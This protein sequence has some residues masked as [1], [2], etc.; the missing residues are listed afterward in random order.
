MPS[1]WEKIRVNGQEMDTYV[2]VPSGPEPFP[3]VVITHHAG[4]LD[5]F[6][7]DIA[8]KLAGEGYAAVA[9][10]FFHRYSEEMMADRSARSS[11]LDDLEIIADVSATVDFLRSHGSVDGERIGVTGFC[12]GGRIAWLTAATNP[13]IK[14]AA[15]YYPGNLMVVWG[16]GEEPPFE[17]ADRISC[18]MLV[19]FAELDTNPSQE[20]MRKLDAE[21]TRLGNAHQFYV[22]PG[23]DHAFMDYTGHRHHKESSEISWPRTL[24]FFGTH[25]KGA[26][27]V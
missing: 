23:A 1:F 19:H 16:S 6:T 21:L 7:R 13:H 9:P 3:A 12:M 18:P 27:A 17:M 15:P 25:L 22:Y 11:H 2:S 10:N 5:Q 14:A 26:V 24:D 8:D 4:G 20:D